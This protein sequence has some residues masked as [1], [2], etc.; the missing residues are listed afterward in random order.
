[1]AESEGT[2]LPDEMLIAGE[3]KKSRRELEARN[4]DSETVLSRVKRK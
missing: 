1:V 4:R 2:V 3:L